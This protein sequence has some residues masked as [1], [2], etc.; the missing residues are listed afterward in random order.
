[1]IRASGFGTAGTNVE[2]ESCWFRLRNDFHDNRIFSSDEFFVLG[3]DLSVGQLVFFVLQERCHFSYEILNVN[4]ARHLEAGS[5]HSRIDVI[6]LA[7]FEQSLHLR[8]TWFARDFRNVVFDR[9]WN[10]F[11]LNSIVRTGV[12]FDSFRWDRVQW[13]ADRNVALHLHGLQFQRKMFADRRH[14]DSVVDQL[15]DLFPVTRREHS[16]TRH[17]RKVVIDHPIANYDAFVFSAFGEQFSNECLFVDDVLIVI[18]AHRLDHFGHRC[19]AD[20]FLFA[21]LGRLLH[22]FYKEPSRREVI[23]LQAIEP[24]PSNLSIAVFNDH[25][26]VDRTTVFKSLSHLIED[27]AKAKNRHQHNAENDQHPSCVSSK[28]TKRTHRKT[29]R[30][31]IV[32]IKRGPLPNC[33]IV[34][35]DANAAIYR[36]KPVFSMAICWI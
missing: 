24:C 7:F 13:N 19:V 3:C 4:F 31:K 20:F 16:L 12:E 33:G 18:T 2:I 15:V 35:A 1:L 22:E 25:W 26:I 9:Y 30:S 28:P 6:V 17:E 23:S 36:S 11:A 29:C 34:P 14:W 5:L 27:G 8:A 21:L 10:N 32:A